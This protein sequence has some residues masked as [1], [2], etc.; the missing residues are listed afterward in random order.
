MLPPCWENIILGDCLHDLQAI[1]NIGSPR[2]P[3][4]REYSGVAASSPYE[5]L[6]YRRQLAGQG[7]TMR[8]VSTQ[9]EEHAHRPA[10]ASH[11]YI[12][13]ASPTRLPLRT[14]IISVCF[15]FSVPSS[16]PPATSASLAVHT[17]AVT[18]TML[19]LRCCFRA[20]LYDDAINAAY[21]TGKELRWSGAGIHADV[22]KRHKTPLVSPFPPTFLPKVSRLAQNHTKKTLT[23][24]P[25]PP[26]LPFRS[27]HPGRQE[28]SHET[29]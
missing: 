25:P 29:G 27:F 11:T 23:N 15:R 26:L 19:L 17:P 3:R 1:V 21:D 5:K 14:G 4:W 18:C 12:A 2:Q 10:F 20:W 13:H 6:S 8:S 9:R 16:L 22:V 7:L 24:A 28:I